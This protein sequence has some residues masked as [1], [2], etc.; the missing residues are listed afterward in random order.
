LVK[1]AGAG[2][3]TCQQ[4]AL[5]NSCCLELAVKIVFTFRK[6]IIFV[7]AFGIYYFSYLFSN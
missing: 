7:E 4:T 2:P 5:I 1:V 3:Q 6:L